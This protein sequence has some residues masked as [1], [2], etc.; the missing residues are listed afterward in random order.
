MDLLDNVCI[1][2]GVRW[3]KARD[4]LQRANELQMP[5]P[6]VVQFRPIER[7]GLNRGLP[8]LVLANGFAPESPM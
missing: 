2:P 8:V 3:I 5:Q 6:R 7:K 4:D 1:E